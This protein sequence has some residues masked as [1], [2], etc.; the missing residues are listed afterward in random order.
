MNSTTPQQRKALIDDILLQYQEGSATLGVSIR[1]LRLEVTG[2]DQQTFASMCNMSTKAL[3]QLENDKGNPTLRT[4]DSILKKFG[5][6]L[7][8][9]AAINN[10]YISPLGQQKAVPKKPARGT[11]PHRS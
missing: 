7:S 11:N 6:R 3:Y 2:F 1:R 9:S 4:V 8:L 10:V 5:L